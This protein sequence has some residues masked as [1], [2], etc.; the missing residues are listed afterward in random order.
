MSPLE[1]DKVKALLQSIE[2]AA[3][4]TELADAVKALAEEAIPETAPELIRALN[5]N[6][7]GAAVAAVDGLIEIGDRA[8]QPLLDLLDNYNYGARAW[9]L[10]ALS[11]IGDPRS[12]S[13]LLDTAENDFALS[14]RRAA[15]YGLGSIHWEKMPND[16]VAAAQKQ[17][18]AVL[19]ELCRDPEWIVRYAAIAAIES[20]INSTPSLFSDSRVSLEQTHQ[21]DPEMAV[22]ARAEL[23]LQRIEH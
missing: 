21:T 10:R 1:T 4:A 14:V 3:N 11:G 17:C 22:K 16:Q 12:L 18:L 5:Y 9:A 13:L 23:A 8:V 6:N 7:P 19:L 15:A 20:L 2:A